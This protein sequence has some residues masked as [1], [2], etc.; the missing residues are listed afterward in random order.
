[1]ILLIYENCYFGKQK[2]AILKNF[3][4]R[5]NS[6]VINIYLNV[7]AFKKLHYYKQAFSITLIEIQTLIFFYV[8]NEI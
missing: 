4:D 3:S 1:M 8:W 6:V 7:H 2:S 5:L